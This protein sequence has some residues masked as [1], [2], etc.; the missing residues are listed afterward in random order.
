MKNTPVKLDTLPAQAVFVSSLRQATRIP[1][2]GMCAEVRQEVA[3]GI[4]CPRCGDLEPNPK[5]TPNQ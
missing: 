5:G 3:E 1:L 2:C 4:W